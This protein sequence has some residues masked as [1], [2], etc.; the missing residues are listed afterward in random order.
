MQLHKCLRFYNPIKYG[1][2]SHF[3]FHNLQP[4]L[5]ISHCCQIANQYIPWYHSLS[6]YMALSN[7]RRI[8]GFIQTELVAGDQIYG[9]KS[10]TKK[11][12][13]LVN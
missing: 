11:A 3:V 8:T 10:G 9:I 13:E 6:H 5:D 4:W 12:L 2:L 7:K 1:F